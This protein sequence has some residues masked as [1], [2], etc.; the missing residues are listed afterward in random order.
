[1]FQATRS[2][3]SLAIALLLLLAGTARAQVLSENIPADALV[4]VGWQGTDNLAASYAQSHL[5]TFI[6]ASGVR[7]FIEKNAA[8]VLDKQVPEKEREAFNTALSLGGFAWRY[9]G[10][11]YVGPFDPQ[12]GGN[13]QPQVALI[14]KAGKDAAALKKQLDDLRAKSEK[15]IEE[16]DAPKISIEATPDAVIIFLGDFPADTKAVLLGQAQAQPRLAAVP[17][18]KAALA[19]VDKSAALV[20]YVDGA[21]IRKL[22]LAS[23][24]GSGDDIAKKRAPVILEVLGLNGVTQ[25]SYSAGFSAKNWEDRLF[26]GTTGPRTG[27]LKL[28]DGKPLD[29][30]LLKLV[31]KTATS[32]NLIRL[33]LPAIFKEFR[34]SLAKID[35]K[36]SQEFEKNL[37]RADDE[38]KLSI[39]KDIL[40][41]LGDEWIF[42]RTSRE[43]DAQ[44][45]QGFGV[46]NK[47]ADAKKAAETLA[48]LEALAIEKGA[49][50]E[51]PKI[52]DL[53]ATVVNFGPVSFGWVIAEGYLVA[54]MTDELEAA[55]N[56]IKTKKD[57]LAETPGVAPVLKQFGDGLKTATVIEYGDP[58]KPYA[59]V[60][61]V[62]RQLIQMF[63]GRAGDVVIPENLIPDPEK[64]ESALVPGGGIIYADPTGIHVR[65]VN[66]LPL[67]AL[68]NGQVTSSGPVI[69]VGAAILLPSLGR[70]RE[71][72]NRSHE[73]A[74]LRGIAQ[75]AIVWSADNAD[76]MPEH[77]AQLVAANQISPKQLLSKRS[78]STPAE[79]TPEQAEA[80]SRD[81]TTIKKVLDEHTDV[82]YVGKGLKSDSDTTQIIAYCDPA[83]VS[84]KDG[85]NIA[86]ADAHVEWVRPHQIA[87]VFEIA[88]KS[89]AENKWPLL[90]APKIES[91]TNAATKPAAKPNTP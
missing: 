72:A 88:N 30:A 74:S 37:A 9:P 84:I 44:M 87:K 68:L 16:S 21:A 2:L 23:I 4:Y 80:A 46:L 79:V 15:A 40:A 55:I 7:E 45:P 34:A 47:L 67:I 48:A 85:M 25:L 73:A 17:A 82:I 38:L 19:Q 70:A 51:K 31:P 11:I 61:K 52:A 78:S 90:T 1:M 10:A 86:F 60:A 56:Q 6:E 12:A 33:D 50:I 41:P 20:G 43:Q 42:F 64:V 59:M 83:K 53:D 71:L 91:K 29:P 75:S 5:K 3:T 57:S 18:F 24:A 89:R 54:S 14:C 77:V 13:M 65:S 49:P 27:L 8:A 26:V 81:W 62:A 66:G 28:F 35:A 76:A 22:A 32:A 69:A 36:T 63:V 39:E 58:Q